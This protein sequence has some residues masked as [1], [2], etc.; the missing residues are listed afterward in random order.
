M[1]LSYLVD[2]SVIREATQPRPAAKVMEWLNRH[3]AS[4]YKNEGVL[5]PQPGRSEDED[6]L[7]QPYRARKTRREAAEFWALARPCSAM[8]RLP[9]RLVA[10]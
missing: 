6:K 2:A 8:G 3:D 4:L 7:R 5:K 9:E 1:D 10:R